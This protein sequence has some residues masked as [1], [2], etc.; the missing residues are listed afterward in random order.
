MWIL[1]NSSSSKMNGLITRRIF[2]ATK[3]FL[4]TRLAVAVYSTKPE[5]VMAAK[6]PFQVS[7]E[8]DKTYFWCACGK[9]KK[10]PF[11][12]GRHKGSKIRPIK[13]TI[14]EIPEYDSFLCG[15]KHTSSPPYCDGT[16]ATPLIQ[17]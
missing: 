2:G 12:D 17:N 11:C 5:V 10:Q 13:F 16:H 6:E 8:P 14:Q 1:T 4:S 3:Q 9:S 7:L 15:C